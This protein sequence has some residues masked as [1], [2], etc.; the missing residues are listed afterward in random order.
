[1]EPC[2]RTARG[3]SRVDVFEVDRGKFWRAAAS[4][5]AAAGSSAQLRAVFMRAISSDGLMCSWLPLNLDP[6]SILT[7]PSWERQARGIERGAPYPLVGA[8]GPG[9]Q[10][11]DPGRDAGQ[12][13][14]TT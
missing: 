5:N 2:R 8:V 14:A 9:L 12:I 10:L 4:S 13:L 1:M 3:A 11:G 7:A 6:L